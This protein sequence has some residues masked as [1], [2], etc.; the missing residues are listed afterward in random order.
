MGLTGERPHI[1][2]AFSFRSSVICAAP[3]N[4]ERPEFRDQYARCARTSAAIGFH[5]CFAEHLAGVV[6]GQRKREVRPSLSIKSVAGP[7]D[8][9]HG[10]VCKA[11]VPV[12]ADQHAGHHALLG[13]G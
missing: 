11:K 6:G 13:A 2:R 1:C 9:H 3:G 8:I 12:V 10:L 7:T 4:I 5:L